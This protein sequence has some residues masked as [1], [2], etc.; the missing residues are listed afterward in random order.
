MA[1]LVIVFRP[2][3]LTLATLRGIY[4][5]MRNSAVARAIDALGGDSVVARRLGFSRSQ[6]S[7][8][9]QRERFPAE[10]FYGLRP[11]IKEKVGVDM[12]PSAWGQIEL[13][14]DE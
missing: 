1:I 10:L 4:G 11:I 14:W 7:N 13:E 9:K 12:P 8:W 2:W 3:L 5:A 6:V